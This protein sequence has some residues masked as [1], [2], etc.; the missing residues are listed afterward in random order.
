MDAIQIDF[1]PEGGVLTLLN[2]TPETWAAFC[3]EFPFGI[4]T[5]RIAGE[6]LDELIVPSGIVNVICS[7]IGLRRLIVPDS[8]RRLECSNNFLRVLDLPHSIEV[9]MASKNCLRELTFRGGDPL[10]LFSLELIDSRL[11]RLDFKLHNSCYVHISNDVQDV[12]PEI[13]AAL[14]NSRPADAV[15]IYTIFPIDEY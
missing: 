14:D 4:H 11:K 15:N 12:S 13:Q 6:F 2:A 1:D 3:L 5:L 8:V 9:L 10:S 7:N